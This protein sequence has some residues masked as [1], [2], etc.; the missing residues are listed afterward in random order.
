MKL[1]DEKDNE[2]TKIVIEDTMDILPQL[3]YCSFM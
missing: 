1:G 3:E 2:S